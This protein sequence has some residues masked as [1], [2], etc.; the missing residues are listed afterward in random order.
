MLSQLFSILTTQQFP[1][2]IRLI[3]LEASQV[4]VFCGLSAEI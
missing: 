4:D 1:E 3:L 2:V